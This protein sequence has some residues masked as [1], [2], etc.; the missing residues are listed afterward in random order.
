M[1]ACK[2]LRELQYKTTEWFL[3]SLVI[4]IVARMS[5]NSAVKMEAVK[6]RLATAVF[7]L[8]TAAKATL[9]SDFKPSVLI[10]SDPWVLRSVEEISP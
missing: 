4:L 5:C 1:I 8:L 9:F 10:A 2:A 7:L 6:E 3:G